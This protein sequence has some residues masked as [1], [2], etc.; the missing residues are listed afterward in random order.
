MKLNF[1]QKP[2]R[3]MN[4]F[5]KV[6]VVFFV[7][8]LTNLHAQT[9]KDSIKTTDISRTNPGILNNSLTLSNEYKILDDNS[10]YKNTFKVINEFILDK[11]GKTLFRLSTPFLA[12]NLPENKNGLGNLNVRFAYVTHKTKK[13]AGAIYADFDL[14]TTTERSL[15]TNKNDF[16]FGYTQAFYFKNNDIF[17]VAYLQSLS[18]TNSG[19]NLNT[20]QGSF[21]FYYVKSFNSNKQTIKGDF[22]FVADYANKFNYS[23]FKIIFVQ[24]ITDNIVASI[25]P[26]IGIGASRDHNYSLGFGLSHVF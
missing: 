24:K 20:N 15:R 7:C 8:H 12:T 23:S 16:E 10:F 2:K 6:G 25:N 5:F 1:L 17:A 4:I 18:L 9:K 22:S 13:Y 11:N 19:P 21:D 14:N 3:N 26:S